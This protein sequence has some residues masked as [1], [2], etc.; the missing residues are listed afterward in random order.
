VQ[1]AAD[2]KA[3]IE[4]AVERGEVPGAVAAFG[5]AT[6]P[7]EV[8]ACG[9][10]RLSDGELE[11]RL[12]EM[13]SWSPAALNDR[14]GDTTVTPETI[15]DL[16]SLT[17]V[18]ATLPS[19]LRLVAEGEISLDEEVRRFFPEARAPLAYASV[20]RLLS[21][22]AGL[23]GSLPLH[24]EA[25][26]VEEGVEVIL[27][28]EIGPGS[29][30][31]YSDPGMILLGA[32]VGRVSGQGLDRF[33]HEQVFAPLGMADTRFGPVTDRQVAAT[34]YR[35]DRRQVVEGVVHDSNALAMGGICGHAG[36]F[37]T[38]GDLSRYARAWLEL[39]ER[40]G[41]AELLREATLEQANQDGTRRG[42]GWMLQG[43]DSSVGGRASQ[44][45]FGHTGFTGTSLW[46][47]PEQGWFG[48]LLTNRVHPSRENAMTIQGLRKRFYDAVAE[49]LAGG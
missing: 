19:V 38:A 41:P 9:V 47:D 46:C 8:V 20:R 40:L 15:Y 42:L 12:R 44:S 48:S 26:S 14:N 17:K 36:L 3:I 49:Q 5:F 13:S 30:Y 33:A 18:V 23:P 27:A 2:P 16:A 35:P 32:L 31:I 45:T 28:A 21:H 24:R 29:P 10:S 7:I 11:G 43:E 6:G 1:T 22:T 39:D 25:A 34:E 37:G 4:L